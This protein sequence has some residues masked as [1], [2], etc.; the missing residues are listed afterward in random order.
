MARLPILPDSE[1]GHTL[2]LQTDGS[3]WAWGANSSGQIGDGTT[4]SLKTFPVRVG[5]E[6]DWANL[7]AGRDHS[8]ALK[9]N[10]TLWSWGSSFYG[11]AADPS[12]LRRSIP[13]QVGADSD[14]AEIAAG[15]N[16]SIADKQDGS[17]SGWGLNYA[18]QLGQGT[19][20]DAST[21]PIPISAQSTWKAIA[22]GAEFTVALF[23]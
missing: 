4:A 21:N 22:A 14:W 6:T 13:T 11:Q 23:V 2:A 17:L 8:M 5:A 10:G 7:A 18:G 15:A 3:L 1:L 16:H 20:A 12:G 9:L 19:C